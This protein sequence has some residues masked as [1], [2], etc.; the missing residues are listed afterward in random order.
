M[1]TGRNVDFGDITIDITKNT[2]SDNISTGL[3]ALDFDVSVIQTKQHPEIT[4]DA[5]K[6]Y[7]KLDQPTDFDENLH[8]TSKFGKASLASKEGF[9]TKN[10]MKDEFS[11]RPETGNNEIESD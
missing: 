1:P 7:F 10:E 4:D 9:D 3:T 5:P 8:K 6:Q 2:K 11:M